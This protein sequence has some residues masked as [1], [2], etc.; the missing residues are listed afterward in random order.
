MIAAWMAYSV[1]VALLLG[2]AARAAEA[3][4][5]PHR[6]PVRGVWSSALAGS[7]LWPAIGVLFGLPGWETGGPLRGL[8]EDMVRRLGVELGP[9]LPVGGGSGV[10]DGSEA[11]FTA[12]ATF[13]QAL[14]GPLLVVWGVASVAL[15]IAI[16]VAGVRLV[17]ESANWRQAEVDGVP[18]S[19][20]ADRGPAVLGLGRARIVVPE[21]VLTLG[22][23]ERRLVLAHELEHL[24]GRD[25]LLLAI[26]L[27]A[28][29]LA[30]W[31]VPLWW[32]LRRLEL[33]A[34]IDCDR[35]V[36]AG[37]T[38]ARDYGE[39]LLRM[40]DRLRRR[41]LPLP[42]LAE[43]AD[44]LRRRIE[45]MSEKRPRTIVRAGAGVL[46][47]VA[48]LVGACEVPSP[49]EVPPEPQV[50]EAARDAPDVDEGDRPA[51]TG[52]ATERPSFLPYDTPPRLEN[53]GDVMQA[54]R[55]QYPAALKAEGVG[56][57]VELWLRIDREGQV[58]ARQVKT[59]SG[60]EALDAAAL[61]VAEVM[62][63]DPA[64]HEGRPTDVWVSQQ[65]TF[66]VREDAS[67]S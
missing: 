26:G 59:T 66:G 61:S 27:G 47:A 38:G 64:S 25:H 16:A 33:A 54:L 11:G 15:G 28:V 2:L 45:T 10:G 1:A 7:L 53:V 35:R 42:A 37:G 48:L 13:L 63:F 55:D 62:R 60:V 9:L 5:R 58:A 20:A 40:A 8:G 52:D 39:L 18:V 23:P 56:G 22:A 46:A 31:N 6:L 43:G 32:Q 50:A 21:W 65:L 3:G 17:R 51:A 44:S 67:G 49:S 34:E 57:T 12:V 36:L 14:D 29:V 24:R 4:L 30:P 19:V 41:R